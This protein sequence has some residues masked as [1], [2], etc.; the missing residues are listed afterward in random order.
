MEPF[1]QLSVPIDDVP[2]L[3]AA[4]ASIGFSTEHTDDSIIVRHA[5]GFHTLV[6]RRGDETA[7][8]SYGKPD[9]IPD[10]HVLIYVNMLDH[11][12]QA[13]IR[14]HLESLGATWG[15]TDF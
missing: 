13:E 10:T 11:N 1:H 12:A 14:G 6:C 7:A 2:D 5:V 15:Y 8:Y 9:S 3:N 4:L